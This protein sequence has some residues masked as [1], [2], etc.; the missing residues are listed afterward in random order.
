M[1]ATIEVDRLPGRFV[2][3]TGRDDLADRALATVDEP[4][5]LSLVVP[6]DVA[7]DAGLPA[8]FVAAWLTLRVHSSL[9]AVGLTAAVAE[10]LAKRAIPCNVIA[11]YHHDHLL[12]PAERADDAVQAIEALRSVS[13]R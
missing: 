5:G 6:E 4:E 7:R 13:G 2:F 11:G 10:A 3:V 12:V 8:G 1:L 9:A